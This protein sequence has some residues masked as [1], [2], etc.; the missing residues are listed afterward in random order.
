MARRIAHAEWVAARNGT[1]RSCTAL[2]SCTAILSSTA[3]LGSTAILSSASMLGC[4]SILGN[5]FEIAPNGAGGGAD[6]S[7]SSNKGGAGGEGGAQ[8]DCTPGIDTCADASTMLRCDD[9][10]S[11]VTEP[12]EADAP[13]C[14]DGD[15]V[16]CLD[17]DVRCGTDET[18]SCVGNAWVSGDACNIG[19]DAGACL[20]V[21]DISAGSAHSCAVLSNGTVRC[22]GYTNLS[23]LFLCFVND[24]AEPGSFTLQPTEVPGLTDAKSIG[25]GNAHNCIVTQADTVRCWGWNGFGRLGTGD[26]MDQPLATDVTLPATVLDL[27]VNVAHACA[28]LADGSTQCWGLNDNGQLGNNEVGTPVF[29]NAPQAVVGLGL[30]AAQLDSGA[31]NTCM[32][33]SGK[34]AGCWGDAA[35]GQLGSTVTADSGVPIGIGGD[36]VDEIRVG[37]RHTCYRTAG[38]VWCFGSNNSGQIGTGAMGGTVSSAFRIAPNTVKRMALQSNVSCIIDDNDALHCW[39]RNIEGQIGIGTSGA[40][41]FV[42]SPTEVTGVGPIKDLALGYDHMCAIT[43][44]DRVM[45]WGANNHGQVGTGAVSAVVASPTEVV[46]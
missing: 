43:M 14:L 29:Y 26:V 36:N 17:G 6:T 42:L 10:G 11:N 32:R 1:R 2:L 3:I 5:D 46:W 30:P 9:N 44:D 45:C 38:D 7:S 4:T 24:P 41:D 12:C 25:S 33:D 39:G 15:C 34:N 19:C 28:A 23:L 16:A 22:W 37:S 27:T 20:T 35:G 8:P 31:G 21:T 18:E 40:G 13:A